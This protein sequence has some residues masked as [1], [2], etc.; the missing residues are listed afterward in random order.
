MQGKTWAPECPLAPQGLCF[1]LLPGTALILFC[2]SFSCR[3]CFYCAP[4]VWGGLWRQLLALE[5]KNNLPF[6]SLI[7]CLSVVR[8]KNA[9]VPKPCFCASCRAVSPCCGATGR[10]PLRTQRLPGRALQGRGPPRSST[11]TC[12]TVG[13]VLVFNG[14]LCWHSLPL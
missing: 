14:T 2:L 8:G 6:C 13:S 5:G 1:Q 9:S 3:H 4:W 12:V 11:R 10:P 7:L